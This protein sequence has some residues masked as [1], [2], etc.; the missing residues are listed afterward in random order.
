MDLDI[1]ELTQNNLSGK[2]F[3]VSTP[4]GNWDDIT[5]RALKTLKDVDIIICEEIKIGKR[6][7]SHFQIE[8]K[9]FPINEHN[10]KSESYKF[11]HD[12]KNGKN[13][14]LIS[15]CGTPLI[16]DPGIFF[17]KLAIQNHIK[18]IPIPGTSSLLAALITS[19]F[20]LSKFL[21][22]GFL[23]PKKEER[24]LELKKLKNESNTIVIFETPYRLIQLLESVKKVF[25]NTRKISV[26]YNLTMSDEKI[27]RGF[28]NDVLKFFIAEKIKKG[29]FIIVIENRK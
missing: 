23:S 12:L 25:E 14:A 10:E 16:S 24:F 3:I 20:D 27:V 21:F 13:I 8:K 26:A 2:L 7:L 18:I 15:D 4:I 9:I 17:V 22:Y 28:T 6:F 11:I 1:Q 5:F 19:G 29:E